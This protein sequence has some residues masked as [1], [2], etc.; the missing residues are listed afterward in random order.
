[1]SGGQDIALRVIPEFRMPKARGSDDPIVFEATNG[2]RQRV[3]VI[4]HLDRC[5]D[6]VVHRKLGCG[7]RFVASKYVF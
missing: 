3:F 5:V 7:Q 2:V 1:M 6:P 4:S